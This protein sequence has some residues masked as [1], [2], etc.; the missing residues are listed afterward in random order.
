M[1]AKEFTAP[2]WV[3]PGAQVVT[4]YRRNGNI[5]DVRVDTVKG[6]GK[7]WIT[8]KNLDV[9]IALRKLESANQA[10]GGYG[11]SV[12]CIVER[13]TEEGQ[14][15]LRNERIRRATGAVTGA[16]ETWQKDPRD[17]KT[18]KDLRAAL[19]RLDNVFESWD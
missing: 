14:E 7:A 8:L 15:L 18:R 10:H 17:E 19:D 13:Y 3:F 1:A 16:F 11:I 6:V 5:S 4:Y 12:Y 2:E 9:R